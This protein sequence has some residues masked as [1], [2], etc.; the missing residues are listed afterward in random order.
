MK[1]EERRAKGLY[2]DQAWKLVEGCTKVSP[3]CANCWSETET[4]MRSNHPNG[5]IQA[6]ALMVVDPDTRKFDGEICCRE[7]NLDLP[8]RRKKPTVFACWNDLFHEDVPV[9]FILDA[10]SV[11]ANPKC[12]QHTFLILTKR[13]ER[14]AKL[15]NGAVAHIFGPTRD[16]IGVDM[17][18]NIWHGVT[19]E[20][21]ETANERIP[22]LLRVPG[23]R[24]LSIEP[25][26]SSV[27]LVPFLF[28]PDPHGAP[29]D[30]MPSQAIH[31]VL[32]GGESGPNARPMHPEW[33][34]SVRD[35]C[36][37]AGVPFVFKQWGEWIGQSEALERLDRKGY[38][39]LSCLC[40]P[41]SWLSKR[42]RAK[43]N[44]VPCWQEKGRPPTRRPHT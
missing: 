33:A 3:G 39:F 40:S 29:T 21:Q 38:L 28:I 25:M 31:A 30:L 43:P 32:L 17:P 16:M 36:A 8:L 24:F 35:Q 6:R 22:H 15:L 1:R 7:D 37:A 20:N 2:W 12:N 34:R 19:C 10:Y 26:L 13:A 11:M 9:D 18:D 27:D 41:Q 4:G 14:M 44:D 42:L 23:K 5:T